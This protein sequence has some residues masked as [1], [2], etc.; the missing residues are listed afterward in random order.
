[1]RLYASIDGSFAGA[2]LLGEYLPADAGTV[3]EFT[4]LAFQ[5]GRPPAVNLSIPGADKID[6]DTELLEFPWKRPVANAAAICRWSATPA[7]DVRETLDDHAAALLGR[8]GVGRPGQAA[9]AAARRA[10]RSTRT[11]RSGRRPPWTWC[12]CT[13]PRSHVRTTSIVN[14]LF[15]RGRGTIGDGYAH[16]RGRQRDPGGGQQRHERDP[17]RRLHAAW[18]DPVRRLR[19]AHLHDH[20]EQLVA[21]RRDAG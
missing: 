13:R 12:G 10:S 1:L 14:A 11:S 9:G 4:A 21:H 16:R 6:P 15:D 2:S 18:A 3:K 7:G 20:V 19:G 5:D 8:R 17:L